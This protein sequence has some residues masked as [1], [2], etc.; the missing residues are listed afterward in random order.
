MYVCYFIIYS[1]E[2][3]PPFYIGSTSF[4]KIQKGYRGSVKSIRY[5]KIFNEEHKENLNLF[6]YIILSKHETRQEALNSELEYQ[7]AFNV[8]KS[9]LFFNES[10][11]SEKGSHGRNVS[12]NLNPMFGKKHNLE[13]R[14]KI[15][16]K[17]INRIYKPFS[18]EHKLKIGLAH[19]NKIMVLNDFGVL[20][21]VDKNDERVLSGLYKLKGKKKKNIGKR[22]SLELKKYLSEKNKGKKKSDQMK[23]RLSQTNKGKKRKPFSQE[24]KDNMSKSK[25][26]RKRTRKEIDEMIKTK[27]GMKYIKSV[28]PYCNFEG[29]G[30]NMKR[31]HF[32]NC[33]LKK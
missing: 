21:K 31:Y 14:R 30:G 27:T 20:V 6:K 26:G 25:K 23:Q 13:T 11:A 24:W 12:G 33:K 7:K 32:E 16:E 15:K 22:G 10:F 19:K 3:L 29:R 28:C 1:G 18:E 8:V 9:D 2:K 5:G 4:K 17:A